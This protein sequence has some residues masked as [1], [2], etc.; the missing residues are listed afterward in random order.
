MGKVLKIVFI[1]IFSLND[2][3]KCLEVVSKSFSQ[4][5]INNF[6]DLTFK[7]FIVI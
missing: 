3:P 5:G 7:T 2:F 1:E 4:M 6:S